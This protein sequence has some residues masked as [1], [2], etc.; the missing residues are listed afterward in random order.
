MTQPE[1]GQ[2]DRRAG[3]MVRIWRRR[4]VFAVVFA[5]VMA[6]AIAALLLLPA[7]YVATGSVIVATQQPGLD[8]SNPAW[9]QKIGDP[10]DLASQLLV[11]HSPRVLRL[12]MQD[13]KA[14]AAVQRDC[15]RV[16]TG[17]I[18]RL[19]SKPCDTLTPGSEALIE[20]VSAR[21]A[22]GSV[23]RSRVIDVSYQ[24]PL[25]DVAQTM[26]NALVNAFLD[27]QRAS[28]SASRG[29]AATWLWQEVRQVGAKLHDEDAKIEAFRRSK[30]L[31]RGAQAPISSERLTTI[32]NQ[33]AAAKAARARAAADL[34]AIKASAAGGPADAPAVLASRTIT[35]LKQ[36]LAVVA[37]QLA[38][39]ERTLGPR[40]PA[41][42]ALKQQRDEIQARIDKEVA[43][44]AASTQKAYDTADGLVQSLTKQQA[45]VSTE[46]S[47]AMADEASIESMVRSA[48]IMRQQYSDLYKRASELETERR[49]L[50]GNTRLVSLAELPDKPFFPKRLPFLAAG[51]TFAFLFGAAAAL[52]RDRSDRSVRASSELSLMAGAPILAQLPRL[53]HAGGLSVLGTFTERDDGTPL[54]GR[55]QGGTGRPDPAGFAA[56]ALRQSHP[57]RRSGHPHPADHVFRPARGKDL[58][59]ARPRPTG[60]EDRTARAGRRVRHAPPERRGSPGHRER[61]GPRFRSARPDA[62]LRRRGQDADRE[63]RHHP[64]RQADRGFDRT[65]HERLHEGR[66]PIRAGIRSGAL[67]Q[68]AGELRDGRP[69]RRQACRWRALLHALGPYSSIAEAVANVDGI[70]NAGGHVLGMTI[71]MVKPDDY[72]LYERL[73]V[74]SAVYLEAAG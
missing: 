1:T 48:G 35:A 39:A 2:T 55:A 3:V 46:V 71:T 54:A 4:M 9:T 13:P 6:V 37:G 52:L 73:P 10:A 61:T 16:R 26:A 19:M 29:A 32:S 43:A 68:P 14:L 74:P 51:F 36:Q 59:H 25:P 56:Q 62:A 70:R 49:I 24:S 53:R 57:H 22:V 45:A 21:Y 63:P 20:Y 18:A 44:I 27:D 23:G 17:L 67:R 7:R 66:R 64:R 42:L 40:H 33:L 50:Q 60:G 8:N 31:M 28:M 15:R 69:C 47:A 65:A 72:A 30:G 38:G 5:A 58:H 34:A 12:A 11:I 41:L